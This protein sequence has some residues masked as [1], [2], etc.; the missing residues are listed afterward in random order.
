[1]LIPKWLQTPYGYGESP[2]A[3]FFIS[4]PLSIQGLP[5]G[6]GETKWLI[7]LILYFFPEFPNGHEHLMEMG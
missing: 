6:N 1:M 4:L 2:N 3:I 5:Y 7:I